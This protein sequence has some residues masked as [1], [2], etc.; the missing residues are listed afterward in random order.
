MP[1]INPKQTSQAPRWTLSTRESR[2]RRET[3]WWKRKKQKETEKEILNE[4]RSL[5]ILFF[6]VQRLDWRLENQ[7][8]VESWTWLSFNTV[9]WVVLL[10]LFGCVYVL[11]LFGGFS[12]NENQQKSVISSSPLLLDLCDLNCEPNELILVYLIQRT[13][14]STAQPISHNASR[15]RWLW[16][17][18]SMVEDIPCK[19]AIFGCFRMVFDGSSWFVL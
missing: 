3:S 5:C 6:F 11:L 9:V 15:I 17:E 8:S 12:T 10:L 2:K 16:K 19:G 13:H 14:S 7:V 4:P 1:L 18:S